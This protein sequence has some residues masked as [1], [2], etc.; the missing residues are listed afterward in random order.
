MLLIFFHL[1]DSAVADYH[2]APNNDASEYNDSTAR[3]SQLDVLKNKTRPS[4]CMT[5][6]SFSESTSAYS[7]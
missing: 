7:K 2:S 4:V 5:P 1:I 6:L 3:P